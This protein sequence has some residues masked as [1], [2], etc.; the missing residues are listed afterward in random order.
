MEEIWVPL[1][2]PLPERN[3]A[4]INSLQIRWTSSKQAKQIGMLYKP[5]FNLRFFFDLLR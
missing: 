5:T 3:L 2:A 4:F 1:P